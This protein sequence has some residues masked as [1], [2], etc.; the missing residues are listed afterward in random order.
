M[1]GFKLKTY[2]YAAAI[3]AAPLSI[4]PALAATPAEVAP[5][6]QVVDPSGGAVGTVIG[7]KGDN[8][9]LKTQKHEV[10]LPLS[11][12]TAS[13]GKL[14]FAMT[15]AQLDAETE[16]AMAEANAAIVAGA[17]VYG[18]DGSLAGQIEAVDDSLVTVKLSSGNTVRLP[19]SGV[20]GSQNG[21]VLGVTTAQL[22][23]LAS[24]AAAPQ[25]AGTETAAPK[26]AGSEAPGGAE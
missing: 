22:N 8:L 21:A 2:V 3:A 6:M 11:S 13:E 25:D 16:A 7:V 10:Q 15:A 9:I 20:S 19:R 18:S 5:G 14:L 26:D 17:S 4:A 12:F 24:Q 1:L 23:E